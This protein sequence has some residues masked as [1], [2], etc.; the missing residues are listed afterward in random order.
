M[1]KLWTGVMALTAMAGLMA[2]DDS[3]SSS[4]FEIPTYGTETALP[5]S[6]SMEVA[7]VDTTYF[8]CFENKWVEVKDSAIVEQFKKGLDEEKVKAKLEELE[9][10]LKPSTPAIPKSSDSKESDKEVQSSDSEEPESSDDDKE[11]CTG[12]HCKDKSSSSKNSGSDNGSGNGGGSDSDPESSSAAEGGD[13]ESSDSGSLVSYDDVAIS[14]SSSLLYG[15]S[16]TISVI[17]SDAVSQCVINVDNKD[18]EDQLPASYDCSFEITNNNT[19]TENITLTFTLDEFKLNGEGQISNGDKTKTIVLYYEGFNFGRNAAFEFLD[20][21]LTWKGAASSGTIVFGDINEGI[22]A[23][24]VVRAIENKGFTCE[25]KISGSGKQQ[26]T[27]AECSKVDSDNRIGY[28]VNVILDA[29]MLKPKLGDVQT[30]V[31][32]VGKT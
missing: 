30:R 1:K 4:S 20:K 25:T 11:E 26:T 8:A 22:S 18:Y 9:E 17:P 21:S 6:C 27:S 3:S 16:T 5:D 12:R 14:A 7:K 19:G 10:L 31:T 13:T 28:I 32:V 29:G 2:C 23:S 15:K 24:Q